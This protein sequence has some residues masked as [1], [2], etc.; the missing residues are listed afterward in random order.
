LSIFTGIFFQKPVR[1]EFFVQTHRGKEIV[2][3]T[4][5]PDRACVFLRE[6][7]SCAVYEDR[8]DI[9]RNFGQE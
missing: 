3:A 7:T 5:T 6:D 4:D 9:C 1:E 8:P 2:V